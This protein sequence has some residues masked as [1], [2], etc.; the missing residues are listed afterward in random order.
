M[1]KF[2]KIILLVTIIFFAL[3]LLF[4]LSSQLTFGWGLGD[5]FY[6]YIQTVWVLIL[7]IAFV[8]MIKKRAIL[9][10]I[11]AGLFSFILLFSIFVSVKAFT[12]D[13]GSLYPWNGRIFMLS[14][15]EWEQLKIE[16]FKIAIDSLDKL[17]QQN[18]TD[19]KTITKKGQFL[20]EN[21]K[22]NLSIEEF[23]KALEINPNYF[24]ALFGLGDSYCGVEKYL[25]AVK[26]FEKAKRIDSTRENVNNRIRNLKSYHKIE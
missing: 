6:L 8:V 7:I 22:W 5:L 14:I 11:S 19:Y 2:F 23:K 13:R 3:V 10:N 26:E 4:M 1:T 9:N 25:E 16:K 17:I 21:K 15:S 24:D 20:N 12:V 18:P